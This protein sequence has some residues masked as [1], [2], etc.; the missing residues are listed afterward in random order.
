MESGDSALR[1]GFM[2]ELSVTS[3]KLRTLFDGLLRTRGLTLARARLLL[4][5]SRHSLA[6]QTELA[7]VLELENPTLVRLLDGLERQGLIRRCAVAGDRRAKQV[8]LTEA[9]GPQVAEIEALSASLRQALLGGVAEEDLAVA[10]RVLA[11]LAR[12]IDAQ[13]AEGLA[14]LAAGQEGPDAPR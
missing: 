2:T 1:I 6:T 11:H 5:L 7:A 13:G 3:R 9:A 4:H 14:R 10:A 12:A 8:M